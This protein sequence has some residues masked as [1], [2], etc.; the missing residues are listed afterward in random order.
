MKKLK[1]FFMPNRMG[2]HLLLAIVITV[3][4]VI[5]AIIFLKVYTRHGQEVQMPNLIGKNSETLVNNDSI[6]DFIFVVSDYVFDKKNQEGTVL[7]QNPY[8][9]EYVKKGRKVYLTVA[10][11]EPPKVKMPALNSV[12]LRQAEIMLKAVGLE[13]EGVIYKPSPYKNAVLDQLYRGRSINVGTLINYGEKITLVVGMDVD[14]LPSD[15]TGNM[16]VEDV[17]IQ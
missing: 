7:K 12:S 8:P 1:A 14:E 16:Q 4:L 2:F 9:D 6:S 17:N 10:S 3:I 11:S 15:S 5:G 13:V